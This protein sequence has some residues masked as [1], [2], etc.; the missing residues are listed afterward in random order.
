[1]N[2][3]SSLLSSF[4]YCILNLS[5]HNTLRKL[6]RSSISTKQGTPND[7]VQCWRDGEF[8]GNTAALPEEWSSLPSSIPPGAAD[9]S[10]A[11]DATLSSG[12][13]LSQ[14]ATHR[15]KQIFAGAWGEEVTNFK[16]S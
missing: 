14:A 9:S 15:Q 8:V 5:C 13:T 2:T 12:H 7:K 11:R 3:Q 10:W 4:W 16:P 1:M 6:E